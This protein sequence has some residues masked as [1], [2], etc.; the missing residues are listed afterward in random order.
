M[1]LRF[2]F[3][4]GAVLLLLIATS[5][6]AQNVVTDWTA[7]ASDAIVTR[8]GKSSSAGALWF[9]YSSIATYD[10]VNAIEHQYQPFY[11]SQRAPEGASESAAAVAAAHRVLVHYFPLQQATLDA[12]FYDSLLAIN[13]PAAAKD[14]GIAAGEAAADALISARAGDGLEANVVY[15][16]GSGPGVWQPTSPAPPATPWLGAMRPFSMNSASQFLPAPPLALASD[17]WAAD[18]N[19]VRTL[20]SVDRSVRTPAQTEIGLFWTE[21]TPPQFARMFVTLATRY[22]LDVLESSRLM[23][24]L[25]TGFSDAAIGVFNAKYTYGFWRPITAIRAG[26]ANPSLTADPSWAP[27]RPTPNHPEYPSAHGS[28]TSAVATL[29]EDYF[30]TRAVH[31]VFDSRV[32]ADGIHTHVFEDTRDLVDEVHWARIYTGF[33]YPHSMEVGQDLGKAI[34]H[35][36]YATRFRRPRLPRGVERTTKQ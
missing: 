26:G 13:D 17:E 21:P 8:G 35:H 20:G 15:V 12:A 6:A 23:A 18:Y 16:P 31:M 2:R 14:D 19:V 30:K 25:W 11:Y 22:Q 24:L 9:A 10:A 33:H 3:S 34:A 29:I 36:L 28:V 4:A 27:L 5:V 32:F 1:D 7:I